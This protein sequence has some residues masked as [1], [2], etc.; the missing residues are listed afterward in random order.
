MSF[1][2]RLLGLPRYC[3][4]PGQATKG[5]PS[6][7]LGTFV[8]GCQAAKGASKLSDILGPMSCVRPNPAAIRQNSRPEGSPPATRRSDVGIIGVFGW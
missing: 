1:S 7:S 8:L 6:P 3:V 4:R 2:A 5:R